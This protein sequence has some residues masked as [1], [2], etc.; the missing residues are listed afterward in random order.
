MARRHHQ[1]HLRSLAA[2]EWHFKP[3]A[4]TTAL[5]NRLALKRCRHVRRFMFHITVQSKGIT[6][7]SVRDE[8]GQRPAE[9]AFFFLMTQKVTAKWCLPRRQVELLCS[10]KAAAGEDDDVDDDEEVAEEV[11]EDQGSGQAQENL[12]ESILICGA[13]RHKC[14]QWPFSG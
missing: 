10:V 5:S 12:A 8:R 2:G 7:Q 4:V 11:G 3:L 13:G 9:G 1:R 14:E 6:S